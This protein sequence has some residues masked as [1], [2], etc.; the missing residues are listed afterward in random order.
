MALFEAADNVGVAQGQADIVPAVEQAFAAER[1]H[2]ESEH[3]AVG[4]GDRPGLQIDG[5]AIALAAVALGEQGIHLVG[6]QLDRQEAVLERIVVEDQ[7]HLNLATIGYLG[8]FIYFC[9]LYG[10]FKRTLRFWNRES[11]YLY[12]PSFFFI[13]A[14]SFSSFC[15]AAFSIIGVTALIYISM[16]REMINIEKI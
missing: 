9:M 13:L 4:A 3:L 12:V 5:E 16:S 15:I 11:L 7:Y 8:T 6:R 1:V 2:V 14:T 10:I